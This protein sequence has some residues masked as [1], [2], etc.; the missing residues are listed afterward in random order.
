M[1]SIA[2]RGDLHKA[3]FFH[4]HGKDCLTSRIVEAATKREEP[5]MKR[6]ADR[7]ATGCVVIG[8]TTT[9]VAEATT[10]SP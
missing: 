2:K 7:P 6:K 9:L 5:R 4:H 10:E 1:A 3:P 8:L